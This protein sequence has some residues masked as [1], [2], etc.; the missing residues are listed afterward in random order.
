MHPCMHILWCMRI[1]PHHLGAIRDYCETQGISRDELARRMGV[2]TSTAY[3]VDSG[4]VDPSPAFIAKLIDA[5]GLGFDDW[6]VIEK[7]GAA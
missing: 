4:D 3:R 1:T 5:T 7:D 6:F 2:A